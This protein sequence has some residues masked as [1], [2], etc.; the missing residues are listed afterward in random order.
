MKNEK[1]TI[2]ISLIVLLLSCHQNNK[3]SNQNSKPAAK[4]DALLN[5]D[6]LTASPANFKLLLENEHVR[7]LEYTL[8]PGQKDSPHTHPPRSSYVVQ[9]GKIK[10]YTGKGEELIFDEKAGTAGW[11]DYA[12]KHYVE[13]IGATTVKIVLTEVK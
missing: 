6:G 5:I 1:K 13:N 3:A 7:V 12:G 2:L 10:V 11:S 9:G 4:Q 8:A